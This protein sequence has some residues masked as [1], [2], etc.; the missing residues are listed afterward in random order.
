MMT[1]K[2][3]DY[4]LLPRMTPHKR[5]TKQNVTLILISSAT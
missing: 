4:L 3:G 5:V 1:L 2:K